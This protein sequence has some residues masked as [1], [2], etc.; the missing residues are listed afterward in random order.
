MELRPAVLLLLL[1]AVAAGVTAQAGFPVPPFSQPL[2]PASPCTTYADDAFIYQNLLSRWGV[3]VNV[4]GCYDA[5]T[6]K[7]TMMFQNCAW[8]HSRARDSQP[9]LPHVLAAL[10][11]RRRSARQA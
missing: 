4:S 11:L 9:S 5:A 2:A 8:E 10:R 3:P 6:A 1:A 7:V